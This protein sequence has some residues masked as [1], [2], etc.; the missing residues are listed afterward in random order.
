MFD[1]VL[2]LATYALFGLAFYFRLDMMVAL[3]WVE[4]PKEKFKK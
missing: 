2:L 1:G 3:N 4:E